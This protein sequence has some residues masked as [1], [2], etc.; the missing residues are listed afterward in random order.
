[1]PEQG[2]GLDVLPRLD[3]GQR[4]VEN[5]HAARF[6]GIEARES[7]SDY[8]AQIVPDEINALECQLLRK[9]MNILRQVLRHRSRRE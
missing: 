6:L 3:A 4:N 8:P 5:H 2:I 1:M 7:V 9:L